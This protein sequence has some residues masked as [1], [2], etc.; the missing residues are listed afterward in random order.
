MTDFGDREAAK[1]LQTLYA[2]RGCF[3]QARRMARISVV[4]RDAAEDD[5]LALALYDAWS[6]FLEST[7]P[8]G[9]YFLQR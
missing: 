5:D 3:D 9:Q 1:R 2:L 8:A 4:L 7:G 6:Q